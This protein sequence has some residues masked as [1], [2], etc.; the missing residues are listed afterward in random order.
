MTTSPGRTGRRY[1]TRSMP[2][3]REALPVFRFGQHENRAD[4]GD[5]FGRI[6]G[7][8]TGVPRPACDR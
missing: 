8:T 7:G 4:L 2:A 1:R 5:R 6:V 3:K